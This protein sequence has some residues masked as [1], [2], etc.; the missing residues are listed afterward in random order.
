V[1][2]LMKLNAFCRQHGLDPESRWYE[3]ALAT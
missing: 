1:S 3:R 2:Y